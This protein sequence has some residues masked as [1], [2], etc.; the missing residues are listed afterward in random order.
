MTA[1]F[2]PQVGST[3]NWHFTLRSEEFDQHQESGKKDLGIKGEN[4]H[5]INTW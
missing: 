2:N 4:I 1:T 3:E 5:E